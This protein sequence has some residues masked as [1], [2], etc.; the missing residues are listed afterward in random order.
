MRTPLGSS[1][2]DVSYI[3]EMVAVTHA[4]C[5]R[6]LLLPCPMSPVRLLIHDEGSDHS[7]CKVIQSSCLC[8]IDD[9][10]NLLFDSHFLQIVPRT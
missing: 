10:R 6:L 8:F 1:L 9:S 5:G 2:A 7:F 3:V 4:F